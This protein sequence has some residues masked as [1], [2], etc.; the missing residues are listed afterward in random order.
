[1]CSH[2][3]GVLAPLLLGTCGR[4]CTHSSDTSTDSSGCCKLAIEGGGGG[5]DATGL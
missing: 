2:P 3:L 5:L 4:P 1:M